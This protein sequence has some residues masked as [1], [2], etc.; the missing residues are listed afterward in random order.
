VATNRWPDARA[1][2]PLD[3][4]FATLRYQLNEAELERYRQAALD[5]G[6]AIEAACRQARP[7]M[8]EYEL[9]GRMAVEANNRDLRISVALVANE[10]R[11][12]RFRHPLPTGGVRAVRHGRHRRRAAVA[13][14]L[15]TRLFSFGRS[16]LSCAAD[17]SRVRGVSAMIA[18][19]RPGATWA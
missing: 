14:R 15:G 10:D 4:E 13:V 17:M 7:G 9:A 6:L 19:T 2:Q 5:T 12:R 1:L 8:T 11:I 3:A 16:M 18:G